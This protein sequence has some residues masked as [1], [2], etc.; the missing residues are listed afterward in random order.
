[1]AKLIDYLNR[2]GERLGS[3]RTVMDFVTF[4]AAINQGHEGKPF[5]PL[6][7]PGFLVRSGIGVANLAQK[8]EEN[9]NKYSLKE[10]II[11]DGFR[12][13]LVHSVGYAIGY[14]SKFLD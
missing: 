6:E 4:G 12:P 5:S 13:F 2:H 14:A 7:N 11:D 3:S 8:T 9:K 10:I 1:M